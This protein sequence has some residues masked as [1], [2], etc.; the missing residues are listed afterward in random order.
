MSEFTYRAFISYSH[1]DA[2]WAKWL[3]HA[4]ESY[5]VPRK[6]VGTTTKAGVVPSRCR[7]IF[8]D[9]DDLS[10]SGDLDTTVKQALSESENLIVICTRPAAASRWVNEEIREFTRLGRKNH[11]FCIVVDAVDKAERSDAS[12]FPAALRESGLLVPLAADARKWADGKHLAKLKVIAGLLGLP[13][14]K[15]RRRDLQK[16][17]KIWAM[18][19]VASIAVAAILVVAVMARITAMERRDSGESL[20]AYKLNELRTMLNVSEDPEDLTRLKNWDQ[21]DLARLIRSAGTGTDVMA[22]SAMRLQERGIDLW[23]NGALSEAMVLF[24]QSWVLLAETYRRDRNDHMTFFELG[25][26]E[27]WIGQTYVDQGDLESAEEAF[28]TY[29][30]ITRRLILLQPEKAQWVLEM[31]FALTNL[32]LLHKTLESNNPERTLQFMQS[33][34]EYNQIALVLDPGNDTYRSELGQSHANLSTAQLNTCDLEGAL[35]SRRE[36][37]SIN[38][39]LLRQDP[40]NP[41]WMDDMAMALSGYAWVMAYQGQNDEAISS[42]ERSLQLLESN[43]NNDVDVGETRRWILQ[44]ERRLALLLALEGKINNAWALSKSTSERWQALGKIDEEDVSSRLDYFEFLIDHAR[45][46]N[47]IGDSE[48][49]ERLL[50]NTIESLAATLSHRYL[51]RAAGNLLVKAAFQY[52]EMKQALPPP[53]F[54]A[55]LPEYTVGK[56][57]SRACFDADRA[58]MKY[59]MLDDMDT[60]REFSRYLQHNGYRETSFIRK[61]ETYSL[62]E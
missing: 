60:A 3:H 44:Y 19:L 10:S 9:R 40:E 42:L 51:N 4:I 56:G 7:P 28:M 17:Q 62:C 27:F 34:L 61:C 18:S 29:T 59:L 30:E 5:R 46:A 24:Q 57:S 22:K 48:M 31:A 53:H 39:T 16:R 13:L 50:A 38:E 55:L 33:S 1:R 12:V 21:Q 54:M 52:W 37:I 49:A 15:L 14:D 25:Q 6:L 2:R 20:V 26:A 32:G 47:S 23:T 8:R 35:Q 36:W 58:V 41:E 11:I 45:F 43:L